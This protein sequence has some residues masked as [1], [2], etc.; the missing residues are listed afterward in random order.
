M[1]FSFA[2]RVG[3]I[4]VTDLSTAKE[5][6]NLIMWQ[7]EGCGS[8]LEEYPMHPNH[9]ELFFSALTIL[10][11]TSQEIQAYSK[12]EENVLICV[13]NIDEPCALC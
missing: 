10:R 9:K 6:T 7:G 13:T 12:N 11:E 1:I 8:P 2:S 4:S 5:A 3:L